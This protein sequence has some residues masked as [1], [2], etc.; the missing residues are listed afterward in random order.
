[1]EYAIFAMLLL[2][3]QFCSTFFNV[4]YNLISEA[5][6][7]EVYDD[8]AGQGINYKIIQLSCY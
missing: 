3:C 6:D 1:M 7:Q 2:V 4:Y 8:I 5:D